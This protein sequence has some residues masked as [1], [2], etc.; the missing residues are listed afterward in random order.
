MCFYDRKPSRRT[1]RKNYPEIFAVHVGEWRGMH[2]HMD[3]WPARRVVCVPDDHQEILAALNDR[4]IFRLAIPERVTRNLPH[5]RKEEDCAL[6]GLK[7]AV[8]YN[9]GGRVTAPDFTI[10]SNSPRSERDVLSATEGHRASRFA[11]RSAGRL[12]PASRSTAGIG[13][14]WFCLRRSARRRSPC[15]CGQHLRAEAVQFRPR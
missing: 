3:F 8:V 1:E 14:Q 5:R 10:R 2:G 6:D 11:A 7:T 9:T 15:C 4:G 13:S 12:R